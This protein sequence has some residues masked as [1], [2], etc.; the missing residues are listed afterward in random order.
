MPKFENLN[1][2]FTLRVSEDD[3]YWR[4]A[5]TAEEDIDMDLPLQM[6]DEKKFAS[7][8]SELVEQAANRHREHIAND[9]RNAKREL[10]VL[11]L[12]TEES[13]Q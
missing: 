9:L 3:A 12:D 13:E 11:G 4:H 10:G 8:V 6:F 7:L 1:I 2:R 5:T